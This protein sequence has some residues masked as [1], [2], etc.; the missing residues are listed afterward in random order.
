MMRAAY[1]RGYGSPEQVEIVAVAKPTI[2]P[3][4]VLIRIYASSVD[5]AD[6]R[7]RSLKA[8]LVMKPFRRLNL[9]LR[10]LRQPILGS[11]LAGTIEQ[12]GE[13]VSQWRVGER[14]YGTSGGRRFGSHA[15]YIAL[16]GDGLIA[17]MPKQ[18]T[19]EE[20]VSLVF[21]G[22]AALWFLE[23]MEP[24]KEQTLLVYGASGAVG[25]MAVQLAKAMGLHV[26]G[27][28]GTNNQAFVREVGAERCY[29]YKKETWLNIHDKYDL[30]F[31]AVGK[32]PKSKAKAMLK[33]EGKYQTVGGLSPAKQKLNQLHQLTYWFCRGQIK[34]VIDRAYA[35]EDIAQAHAYVD[36]GHKRGSV[37]VRL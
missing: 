8:P 22:M 2:Q 21:G 11:V 15:E 23:N 33:P 14:V 36:Q 26:T 20:A 25:S 32:F 19:F 4:E 35:L 27:V 17:P 1:C 34:A 24:I 7:R 16:S 10:Q 12:V 29:D 28:A 31:D 18:A 3:D 5:S 9:G 13:R 30:V 6:A 37:I